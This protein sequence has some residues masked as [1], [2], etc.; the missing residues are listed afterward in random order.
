MTDLTWKAAWF[1]IKEAL[2]AAGITESGREAH[3]LL[4]EDPSGLSPVFAFPDA[5]IPSAK[6]QRI[7]QQVARRTEREP[8]AYVRG[9]A[10]FYSLPFRV[11]PA[12]LIPRPETELLVEAV[13]QRIPTLPPG[14]VLELGTGSGALV[15]TLALQHPDRCFWATDISEA[16]LEVARENASRHRVDSRIVFRQGDLFAPVLSRQFAAIICNPPYISHAEL[17]TLAPEVRRWEPDLALN[18]GHDGF[19]LFRRILAGASSHLHP[20]GLLAL[21]VGVNQAT[22]VSR[23]CREQGAQTTCIRDYASIPRVIL[24]KWADPEEEAS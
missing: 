12:V 13:S 15:V 22:P 6:W 20:Q 18:G 5:T 8:L 19:S 10:E 11:S 21:E 16:A 4:R 24:A 2:K 23:W 1:Q 3:A 7:A 14:D 9:A 17:A